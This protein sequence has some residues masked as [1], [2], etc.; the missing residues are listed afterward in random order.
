M[1][2]NMNNNQIIETKE[3]KVLLNLLEKAEQIISI[4]NLQIHL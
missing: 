4:I 1:N 2:E 3:F